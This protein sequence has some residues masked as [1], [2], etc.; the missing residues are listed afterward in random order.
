MP[1][2]ETPRKPFIGEPVHY[3]SFGT[4]GGEYG[5][6]CRAATVT[7]VGAWV[8]VA[9]EQPQGEPPWYTATHRTV[10]QV[11]RPDACGLMVANPTGLFF[12]TAVVHEEPDGFTGQSD[13]YIAEVSPNAGGGTWHFPRDI[14]G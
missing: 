5:K 1:E 9:V 12:N 13:G 4:P 2:P 6:R 3:V 10:E 11:W 8:T 7:E 14:C